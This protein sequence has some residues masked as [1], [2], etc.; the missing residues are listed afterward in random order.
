MRGRSRIGDLKNDK[1]DSG[2]KLQKNLINKT[3]YC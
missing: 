1:S 2:N 3:D